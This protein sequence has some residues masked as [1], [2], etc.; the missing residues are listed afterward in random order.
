[1]D[2]NDGFIARFSSKT[3]TSASSN[4]PAN[5]RCELDYPIYLDEKSAWSVALT[6]IHF[7]SR[8]NIVIPDDLYVMLENS[9]SNGA[10]K[11]PIARDLIISNE[12]A[13]QVLNDAL[14][15]WNI[16]V[17]INNE[18]NIEFANAGPQTKFKISENLA[19]ILG[20]A[21]GKQKHVNFTFATQETVSP[22]FDSIRVEAFLPHSFFLYTDI[23]HPIIVG[24][25]YVSILKLI[26]VVP[27]VS[28]YYESHHLDF[29]PLI[30]NRVSHIHFELRLA[31]GELV[32]FSPTNINVQISLLFKKIN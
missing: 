11:L 2:S 31:S 6:S 5:F 17:T 16:Y 26:P 21:I 28:T 12:S 18:G 14:N 23:I 25:K 8:I 32:N 15:M 22:F 4:T 9:S 3:T 10:I 29:V 20:G 7:P 13:V 1:M 27:N 19:L 24:S 30:N